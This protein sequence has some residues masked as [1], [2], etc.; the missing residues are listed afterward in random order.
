MYL[1]CGVMTRDF[2]KYLENMREGE[3]V[4]AD[5]GFRFKF[6]MAGYKVQDSLYDGHSALKITKASD[7]IE[8]KRIPHEEPCS[9]P[10]EAKKVDMYSHYREVGLSPSDFI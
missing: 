10:R 6:P 7:Y 8:P 1:D 2:E 5:M 4:Y 9:Y 3:T